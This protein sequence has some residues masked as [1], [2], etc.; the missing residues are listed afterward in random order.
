[1]IDFKNAAFLK[2]QQ[3]ND[4]TYANNLQQILLPGEAILASFKAV[5]DGI[6]FTDK[7][8]IA[9]NIQGITGKKIDFTSLPYSKI[10]AF[11]IETSGVM[12][13]DCELELWFSGLGLV[14]FEFVGKS[15]IAQ[16]CRTISMR[17]L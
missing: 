13:L 16:I 2:M 14:K 7:R 6:V 17:V 4:S 15:D 12:D 3:V 8:I 1:M 5:R 11:S 9:L 10:Q